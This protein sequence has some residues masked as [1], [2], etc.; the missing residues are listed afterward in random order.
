M[1]LLQ[2]N[3]GNCQVK[4]LQIDDKN[5]K[6]AKRQKFKEGAIVKIEL[7]NNRLAFGRLLPGIAS[8]IAIYNIVQQQG[9]ETS[10]DEIVSKPVLFYCGI[11]KSIITKGIFEIIG[12]KPFGENEKSPMVPFFWQDIVDI[13]NCIIYWND[14]S[15]RKVS[16]E[17]CI[18][19]ERSSVWDETNIIQR[20]EDHFKGR[21]NVAVEHQK[22]I[23]SKDDIRYMPPPLTLRWDFDKEMFYRTDK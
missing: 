3:W 4:I 8:K 5:L 6:M 20:I 13:N 18:G 16:S 2:I 14:G 23:L 22:V 9:V 11:F 1:P 17:E 19:L 10:I 21:K 7:P 15:E 12:I